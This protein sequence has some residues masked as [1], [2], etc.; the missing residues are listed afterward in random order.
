MRRFL[1]TSLVAA[2]V[3]G[4]FAFV[5]S[6]PAAATPPSGPAEA[7]LKPIRGLRVKPGTVNTIKDD[8]GAYHIMG[9]IVNGSGR[10][11]MLPQVEAKIYQANGRFL[12]SIPVPT[13]CVVHML[14]RAVAPFDVM[15][16]ETKPI[17]RVTLHVT[18]VVTTRK[19]PIGVSLEDLQYYVHPD[20]WYDPMAGFVNVSG[21]IRNRSRSDYYYPEVCAAAFTSAGKFIVVGQA[22]T[23]T[24]QLPRGQTN[25]FS[26]D[27]GS[28]PAPAKVI[29][30]RIYF[31][32]CTEDDIVDNL[33]G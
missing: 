16:F 1:I 26:G 7:L 10:K 8:V 18:G 6:P 27:I 20:A 33:C 4:T 31:D 14:P 30:A 29:G 13:S 21:T 12:R 17:G 3:A 15:F 22:P 5:P 24:M 19:F 25:A 9:E 28:Y 32:A 11:V 23:L 2:V